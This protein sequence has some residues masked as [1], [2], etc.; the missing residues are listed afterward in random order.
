MEM[1]QRNKLLVNRKV[2]ARLCRV[3]FLGGD[4]FGTNL[5]RR[6]NR[7]PEQSSR[8]RAARWSS[9]GLWRKSLLTAVSFKRLIGNGRLGS[10]KWNKQIGLVN[11]CRR[12][13]SQICLFFYLWV[14]NLYFTKLKS[15]IKGS[16]FMVTL[17]GKERSLNVKSD[18][19]D[20]WILCHDHATHRLKK[21]VFSRGFNYSRT[22]PVTRTLKGNEKQFELQLELRRGFE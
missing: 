2:Y 10:P 21:K 14:Y 9:R 4:F 13:V 1:A 15:R 19:F 11:T 17:E 12:I 6:S 3:F 16:L 22:G 7:V 8:G 18:L 20:L 5:N